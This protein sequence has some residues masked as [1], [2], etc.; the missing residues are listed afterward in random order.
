MKILAIDD[1]Q[2]DLTTLKAVLQEALGECE[3]VTALSGPRGIELAR[4]Q[5]PDVIL[6]DI[7]MPDMDGYEVCRRLKDAGQTSTI[8]VVFMTALQTSQDSRIKALQVGAETFLAKPLDPQELVAQVR[9]MTKIKDSGLAQRREKP[10]L[11]ALVAERTREL[12]LELARRVQTQAVLQAS[13]E[14]HRA[15]LQTAMDGIWRVDMLGRLLDVNDAYCTMSGYS[16]QELLSMTISD[17]EFIETQ[18]DT[19]ARIKKIASVG[20]DRFESRHRRKDGSSFPVQIS[21]QFKA[22]GGGSLVVFVADLTERNHSLAVANKSRATLLGILEDQARDQVALRESEARYRAVSLTARD[23]IVSI[24]SA[25][26][27]VSWNPAAERLFGYTGVD[28]VGQD[29]LLLIPERFRRRHRDGIKKRLTDQH[30]P[31]NGKAVEVA[32]RHRDGSEIALEISLSRWTTG[33][34]I[35]FTSI[36]RDIRER[37]R[38]EDAI[39]ASE[40]RFRDI[41]NTTDGIVW[42]ADATTFTFTF[43]SLQAERLLGFAVED[44]L[45]PGFWVQHLHPDDREWVPEFCASCT[46]RVEP[47]NFEYRFIAKDGR[48]V[49]LNDIVTV[50]SEHGAPRWLRGIMVDITER[51]AAEAQLRKLSL[52]VEQSPESIV[53]TNIRAEIEYVNAAFVQATG[54]SREELLGR[55]PRILHSGKTPPQTYASMWA[56]L[57]QGQPW[58]GEFV[59]RRKDGSEYTEFAILTPLQQRDG[60]ISHYVAVK[61]D[62]TEKKRLGGELDAHRHRLEELVQSRTTELVAARRQADAANLAKSSF[63]ANMSHEIRTPL[64]AIIGLTHLLRGSRATQLQIERLDKI[65]AAG[66][67]LLSIIND[68]LDL[69][70]IEAER[71]QLETSNFSLSSLIDGVVSIIGE[72]ARAKGLRMEVEVDGDSVLSCLR[73]DATR[74][75]QAL[76][77]Y[78]SNAVKFTEQGFVVLRAK[79][80]HESGDGLTLRFEVQ[81]SG[82]GIAPDKLAELFQAFKQV[83]A[84]TTR[85]YG[86]TG[87]GLVITR[88]ISEL[89]GGAAGADSTPG[90]GSR[91]WFTARLQRGDGGGPA[92]P[93]V[94]VLDAGSLLRR[95]HAGARVLLAEDNPVNREVATELLQHVGLLVDT[96]LDGQEALEMTCTTAYDLILMDMQMP[97][98]DGLAATWAIRNVAGCETTPILAM[99]A[100]AFVEDRQ[101][102]AAAGMNDF[103]TKP[104]DPTTLYGV[105][106]RW[107][108]LRTPR[109]ADDVGAATPTGPLDAPLAMPRRPG[110]PPALNHFGGLDTRQGLA[111]VSGNVPKYLQLLQ[112]FA[113][114]HDGDVPLLRAELARRDADG[115]RRRLHA[116]KG[117][118]GTLGAVHIHGRAVALEQAIRRAAAAAEVNAL[119]DQLQA[120]QGALGTVLAGLEFAP[121]D[122][123]NAVA[124]PARTLA[125]LEQMARLLTGFDTASADAFG[126]NRAVLMATLGPDAQKLSGLLMEFDYPA[127]LQLVQQA[128]RDLQPALMPVRD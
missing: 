3:L 12:E 63:L 29:V 97:R 47:H 10:E 117:V 73:G 81:D 58:K 74:L 4:S 11:A 114:R 88:R 49:W 42:E 106:L 62:V 46:G 54:Y 2:D 124:D 24:D 89:M 56:A 40:E 113:A 85:N 37:K 16:A 69:S 72:S 14:R 99:T 17:L 109:K 104:V 120:S 110:L 66:R 77:N 34:G 9:A 48:A 35:F 123:C 50:V 100:N 98:M 70:K 96:A 26:L 75:R 86:G 8:P 101:A 44:W 21:V 43:I 91:F 93:V 30:E 7:G 28:I 60:T 13:E 36:M 79:L 107:L 103:I 39:K 33:Q 92:M 6:L 57:S 127:A 38:G 65:D 112:Q 25:G 108:A 125:V 59:N 45:T 95:D 105:L 68:I 27:V 116:L 1:N 31:L 53:I 115:S 87:L 23:A 32:G 76:L 52:A 41:V 78:A 102:C 18:A 94:N 82:I 67:H 126:D 51:K 80:L 61:E 90:A 128:V 122:E 5:D 22:E 84:T 118:A 119:V 111:A 20:Q 55:N 19:A 64:N 71:M 83:D 15:I 121:Q